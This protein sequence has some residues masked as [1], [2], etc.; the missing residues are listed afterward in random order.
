[1]NKYFLIIFI[2]IIVLIIILSQYNLSYN[3]IKYMNI[4][5]LLEFNIKLLLIKNAGIADLSK[6]NL[7]IL[8]LFTNDQLLIK[9]HRK[10]NNKYGKLVLTYIS[11]TKN[12]NEFRDDVVVQLNR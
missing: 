1:M 7:K 5:E 6:N 8:D 10:L 11:T 2:I 9:M 4:Y 12:Y 3:D